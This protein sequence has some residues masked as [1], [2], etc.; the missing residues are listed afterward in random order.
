MS[1]V[2][3]PDGL[4]YVAASLA[5]LPFLL[6]WQIDTVAKHRKRSGIKYPQMYA[7]VAQTEKSRDA[8]LFNCAQR[9]HQNTMEQLPL[10]IF[11]GGISALK[12]PIPVAAAI[13]MWT[14][15]RV[16]YT[17]GY[18]TGDPQKRNSL[19]YLC[20]QLSAVGMLLTSVYVTG[21]WMLA[22]FKASNF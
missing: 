9:A 22:R 16:F 15:A 11:G 19:I 17:R 1:T 18:I 5:T 12:Y 7:E 4:D 2:V 10:V 8:L 3:I 6:W 20:G 21:G 14:V 13:L